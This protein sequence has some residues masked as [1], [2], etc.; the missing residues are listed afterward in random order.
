M[1]QGTQGG[2]TQEHA[3][4]NPS[5]HSPQRGTAGLGAVLPADFHRR[6][7]G[8]RLRKTPGAPRSLEDRGRHS[9]QGRSCSSGLKPFLR[10]ETWMLPQA[11]RERH[12]REM[13]CSAD[14]GQRADVLAQSHPQRSRRGTIG[15]QRR[16]TAPRRL[17]GAGP[18]PA[19]PCLQ[20]RLGPRSPPCP[21]PLCSGRKAGAP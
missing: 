12:G 2:H 17:Q 19:A 15:P 6:R 14:G 7:T 1:L 5:G 9:T 8:P 18:P 11:D 4:F 10:S 13:R 16:A 3:A 20:G 21:P